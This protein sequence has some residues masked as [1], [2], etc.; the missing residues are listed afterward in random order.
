ME[1]YIVNFNQVPNLKL[2]ERWIE[3]TIE[4][5]NFK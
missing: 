5:K 1:A 3:S 2:K 4:M